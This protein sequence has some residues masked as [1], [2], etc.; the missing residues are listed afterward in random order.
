M[1]YQSLVSFE[2]WTFIAQLLN[3]FLQIWLFKKFL[4]KPVKAILEK[5][6]SEV[7]KTYSDAD[8]AMN[9]AKTAKD[10]YEAQLK[11]ARVD[12]EEITAR[13]VASA[14]QRSTE[15]IEAARAEANLTLQKAEKAIELDRQ[16]AMLEARKEISGMAVELASKLIS[17][18]ISEEDNQALIDGFIDEYGKE[19]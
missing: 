10:E 15:I 11:N 16:K 4:F 7:E 9:I 17:K 8:E 14:Q 12:A 13:T 18:E 19:Q 1:T 5:R 3:F 6:R 2:Y